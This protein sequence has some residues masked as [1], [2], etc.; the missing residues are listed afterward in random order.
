MEVPALTASTGQKCP[1]SGLWK[2][3]GEITST[4]TVSKGDA[5]PHYCGKKVRWC[6]LY[7]C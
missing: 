1:A 5:M 6:F 7:S 4:Q 3:M 2:V